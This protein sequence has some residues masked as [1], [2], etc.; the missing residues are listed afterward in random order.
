[1]DRQIGKQIQRIRKAKGISQAGLARASGL[2]QSFISSVEKGRKSPTIR[3][4]M[5]LAIA[6]NVP[7][8]TFLESSRD[9]DNKKSG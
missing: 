6:L 2:A 3:S 7:P 8:E 9:Q 1:M 4:L 5:K